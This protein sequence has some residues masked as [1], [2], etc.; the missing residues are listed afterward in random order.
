VVV[1]AVL[2]EIG[3]S[4]V[5]ARVERHVAFAREIAERA[6]AH[7]RLEL[8]MEPQL[9]V[10]CYRYRPGP[11]IDADELNRVILDR[12]RRETAVAPSSTRV[13]GRFAIRPCFINPRTTR[14]EVAELVDA[15]IRFGD[16][17]SGV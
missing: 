8:L 16:D 10:V 14:R 9:S 11:G 17:L 12:L 2:R 3:R 4:G 6:K 1:W 15:V 7:P 13:G 5:V